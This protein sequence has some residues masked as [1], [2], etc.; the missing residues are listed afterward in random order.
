MPQ[1][2][3]IIA[4]ARSA[5]GAADTNEAIRNG[6]AGG[7]DFYA[8]ENGITIGSKIIDSRPVPAKNCS[9]CAH[10]Q[11]LKHSPAYCTGREDLEPPYSK[12]HPFRK[13]PADHGTT[14]NQY[15]P[16]N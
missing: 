14:C 8:C 13:L 2:A 4:M 5:F 16:E 6:M 7:S 10:W 1:I 3:A 15:Q 11:K 12:S 9:T